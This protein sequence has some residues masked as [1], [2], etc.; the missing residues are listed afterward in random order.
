MPGTRFLSH[1]CIHLWNPAAV[2][3]LFDTAFPWNR[4]PEAGTVSPL[5]VPP[6]IQK[7]A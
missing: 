5:P 2:C 4:G 3:F 1:A 6:G 7:K